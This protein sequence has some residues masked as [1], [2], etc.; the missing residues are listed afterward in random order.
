M[1]PNLT[2]NSQQ[3]PHESYDKT[4]FLQPRLHGDGPGS[5]TE[6]GLRPPNVDGLSYL[7]RVP[8]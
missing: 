4:D 5:G 8:V 1:G 7:D 6:S 3:Q 2:A